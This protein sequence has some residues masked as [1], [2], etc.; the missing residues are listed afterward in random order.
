MYKQLYREL[1]LKAKSENRKKHSGVYYESHHIVPEF[2]FK[3]RKRTGPAGHLDGDPN[4]KDNLVLLTFQE[5]I[6]AHYYLYEINKHTHYEYPSGSALQFFFI[7][8]VGNHVRQRELSEVDA[9][10]LDKMAHLRE[11]GVQSISKARKGKMPVVDAVTR[12]KI[13]SVPVDHPKVIS[14]EWVHHSK[15][16]KGKARTDDTSGSNNSNYRAMTEE[17]KL[18]VYKCIAQTV[19]DNSQ[20]IG[21]IFLENLKKEFTEFKKISSVWIRNHLGSTQEMII[22]YNA[23]T[24]SNVKFRRYYRSKKIKE[25]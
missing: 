11:I 21:R 3:N 1:I 23:E 19:I 12:E 22:E 16:C 9:E 4:H 2:M 24:N 14:G 7:K 13:G 17:R 15:G 8:A 18:R 20:F 6:M 25:S 10:F 5:H